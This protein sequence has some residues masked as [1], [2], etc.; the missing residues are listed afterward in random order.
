MFAVNCYI[1]C[2]QYLSWHHVILFDAECPL[3]LFQTMSNRVIIKICTDKLPHMFLL[4]GWKKCVAGF[5]F[6]LMHE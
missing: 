6:E 1:V 4:R 2:I 5:P 3:T